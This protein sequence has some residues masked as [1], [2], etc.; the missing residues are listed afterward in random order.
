MA[1]FM[2]LSFAQDKYI[3]VK[4]LGGSGD[5]NFGNILINDSGQIAFSAKKFQA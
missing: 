4:V 3:I 2:K 5:T 1:G